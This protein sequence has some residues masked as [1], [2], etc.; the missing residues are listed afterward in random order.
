MKKIFAI[1]LALLLVCSFVA[2]SD[3]EVEKEDGTRGEGSGFF[4]S[5]TGIIG[6][7]AHVV[8]GAEKIV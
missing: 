2:C 1:L 3:E 5:P 4:V 6:T 7:C 8:S